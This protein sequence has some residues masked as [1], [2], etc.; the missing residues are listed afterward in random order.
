LRS[1]DCVALLAVM[2]LID[3]PADFAAFFTVAGLIDR[4]ADF[5]AFFAE[6]GLIHGPADFAAHLAVAGLILWPADRVALVAIAGVVNRFAAR[7]GN[8]FAN[9]V[10]D[11]L[12]AGVM[13]LLPDGFLHGLVAGPAPW[14]GRTEVT[15]GCGARRRDNRIACST[16]I[17]RVNGTASAGHQEQG[18][19][20]ASSRV[21][22][23][24]VGSSLATRLHRL[25]R[26]GGT[27]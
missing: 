3:G 24:G 12:A 4:S 16:A 23:H 17:A 10:V 14:R 21:G 26:P 27:H 15:G 13:L 6:A 2:R 5:A 20:Q 22:F 7:D 19:K 11:R 8:R 25:N 9:R 1:A 18:G